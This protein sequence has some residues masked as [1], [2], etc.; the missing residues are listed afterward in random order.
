MRLY[1]KYESILK[2]NRACVTSLQALGPISQKQFASHAHAQITNG[3][4]V[5]QKVVA[6]KLQTH[7]RDL[8][9]RS[10][11]LMHRPQVWHLF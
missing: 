3:N 5:P 8:Q 9:W 6:S 7:L 10:R 1:H 2:R 11:M 4:P